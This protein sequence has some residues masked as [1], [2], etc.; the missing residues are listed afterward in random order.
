M[1]NDNKIKSYADFITDQVA[2][3]KGVSLSENSSS[4][5]YEESTKGFS[6]EEHKAAFEKHAKLGLGHQAAANSE[7]AEKDHKLLLHHEAKM[8][9]HMDKAYHHATQYKK[10]TGKKLNMVPR[11]QPEDNHELKPYD[12][13]VKYLPRNKGGDAQHDDDQ[14]YL[15]KKERTKSMKNVMDARD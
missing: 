6:A 4:D 12:N 14:S 10:L 9:D 8:D 15:P 2:K 13:I 3:E 11:A 5:A 1:T 7:D